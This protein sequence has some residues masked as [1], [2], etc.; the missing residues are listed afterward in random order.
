MI[1]ALS[2][3]TSTTGAADSSGAAPVVVSFEIS[4]TVTRDS[5]TYRHDLYQ[6][7]TAAG[8]GETTRSSVAHAVLTERDGFDYL[9]WI[10]SSRRGAGRE[11]I[12]SLVAAALR[13]DSLLAAFPTAPGGD[14]G[15]GGRRLLT[16]AG[17]VPTPSFQHGINDGVIW[18]LGD[19]VAAHEFLWNQAARADAGAALIG[20]GAQARRAVRMSDP[21]RYEEAA[22]RFAQG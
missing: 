4:E 14:G 1:F 19:G 7:T 12:A 5:D 8:G 18:T 20:P 13:D 2:D 9:S 15:G 11:L 21:V 6:I 16:E 22:R 17:F 10:Q 3:D